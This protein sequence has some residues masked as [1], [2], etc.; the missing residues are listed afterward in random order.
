MLD[1]GEGTAARVPRQLQ[2]EAS[3]RLAAARD[4]QVLDSEGEPLPLYIFSGQGY[5]RSSSGK[6]FDGRSPVLTVSE[7][8]RTTYH[9]LVNDF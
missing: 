1:R 5:S 6:L 9:P 8:G 3:G 2:V 7:A 4:F